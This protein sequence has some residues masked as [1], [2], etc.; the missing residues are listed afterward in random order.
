M[1]NQKKIGIDNLIYK[2][3]IETQTQ[4]TNICIPREKE[5]G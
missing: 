1:W 4:R 5:G 3:K 2:E